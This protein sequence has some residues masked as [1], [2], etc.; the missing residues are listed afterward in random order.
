VTGGAQA[1]ASRMAAIVC[2]LLGAGC[3]ENVSVAK[4]FAPGPPLGAVSVLGFYEDGLMVADPTFAASLGGAS[5]RC[6]AGY[7]P[8][9]FARHASLSKAIEEFAKVKGPSDE[10][11]SRLAPAAR[12]D[13]ILIIAVSRQPYAVRWNGSLDLAPPV[14]SAASVA[15]AAAG[16][17]ALIPGG[18]SEQELTMHHDIT[19]EANALLYS[20]AERRWIGT[21]SVTYAGKHAGR[22]LSR[23]SEELQQALRGA[24]CGD[25]DWSAPVD[26]DAIAAIAATP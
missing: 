16:G 2:A 1:G 10:L 9:L 5:A 22:A 8:D 19:L 13:T 6:T 23:F 20:V 3:L 17:G 15:G 11:L 14:A 26:T 18:F 12:G 24:T 7:G 4:R 25:W 21:V